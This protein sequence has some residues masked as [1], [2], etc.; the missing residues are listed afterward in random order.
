VL[1]PC[2]HPPYRQG[3]KGK[4]ILGFM[5]NFGGMMYGVGGVK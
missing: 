2:S 5:A 1:F 3:A 4:E